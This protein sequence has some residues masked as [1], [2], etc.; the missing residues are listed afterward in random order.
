MDVPSKSHKAW[1]EIV[2][3]KKTFQLKFLATKILL[4]RLVRSVKDDPSSANVARCVD[5][6]HAIFL[7]NSKMPSVQ[8]DLQTIFG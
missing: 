2:T 7:T 8:E 4:G 1:Q 6:L 5:D 3:E